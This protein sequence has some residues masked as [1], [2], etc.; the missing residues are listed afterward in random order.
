MLESDIPSDVPLR[1][2]IA[3]HN[4]NCVAYANENGFTIN[5]S[6][7]GPKHAAKLKAL[8]I[9]PVVSVVAEDF[10]TDA[11]IVVCP[12]TTRDDANCFNCE[13]CQKQHSKIIGFPVHG[14]RKK[15]AA[16]NLC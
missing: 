13:L 3:R 5:I 2:S 16:S 6:A 11:D 4:R 15:V 7:N 9:A 12:A 1:G 10:K 8:K 14:S